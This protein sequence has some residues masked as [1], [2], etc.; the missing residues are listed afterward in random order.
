MAY[1]LTAEYLLNYIRAMNLGKLIT[2]YQSYGPCLRKNGSL[3]EKHFGY[4][5]IVS[6][7]Y[8]PFILYI[9]SLI[10]LYSEYNGIKVRVTVFNN[11]A[12]RTQWNK[13][14]CYSVQQYCTQNTME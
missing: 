3:L 1:T 4:E 13:G 8:L 12:L 10:I 14:T 2:D 9:Y 6:Q 5:H 11:I 7:T